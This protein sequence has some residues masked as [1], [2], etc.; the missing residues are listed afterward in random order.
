MKS[1]TA[2]ECA[3]HSFCAVKVWWNATSLSESGAP[4]CGKCKSAWCP[5]PVGD[6]DRVL[7]GHHPLYRAPLG[8]PHP[9]ENVE[10]TI[11]TKPRSRRRRH[12]RYRPPGQRFTKDIVLRHRRPAGPERRG[13][14]H[15]ERNLFGRQSSPAAAVIGRRRPAAPG[16][17]GWLR[18]S[19]TPGRALSS[20]RRPTSR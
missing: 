3:C 12:E 9:L 1:F 18:F 20:I 11:G 16:S 6:L 10:S 4:S 5:H 7:S 8:G 15:P 17:T 2:R 19:H 14:R 13:A